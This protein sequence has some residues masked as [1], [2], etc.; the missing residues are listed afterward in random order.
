MHLS[1]FIACLF[2]DA[3][4]VPS[5]SEVCAIR[6]RTHDAVRKMCLF[7]S[8]ASDETCDSHERLDDKIVFA[9]EFTQAAIGRHSPPNPHSD[10]IATEK[11]FC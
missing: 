11:A 7:S 10:S 3:T 4:A 5:R 6:I 2:A 8:P 1:R 9:L